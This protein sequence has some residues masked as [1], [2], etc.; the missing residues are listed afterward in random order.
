MGMSIR[1]V[2]TMLLGLGILSL[3]SAQGRAERLVQS[4]TELRTYLYFK[5][6]ND[7]VQKLLPSGW[8]LTSGSGALDGAN[9]AISFIEGLAA[10][11]PEDKPILNQGKFAVFIVTAKSQQTGDEGLMVVGGFASQPQAA[12]GAYGSYS[13]ARITMAKVA[14]SEGAGSTLVEERWDVSSDA[15]DEIHVDMAYERGVASRAH[16]EPRNYSVA[17]PGFYRVY[18]ADVVT[19]VVHSATGQRKAKRL[20]FRGAGPQL[21]KV[22]DGKEQLVAVTSVPAYYRQ[23]FLPE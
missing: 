16:I 20:D 6:N 2:S 18:K 8:V 1:V 23:I 12:P 21:A 22:F 17:R 11:N 13:P 5:A 19:D 9:F 10:Q 15:G 7:A 3:T 4:A 14:H